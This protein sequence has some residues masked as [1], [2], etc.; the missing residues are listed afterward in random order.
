M[1]GRERMNAIMNKKPADKLAWTTIVDNATLNALPTE[2][3]GISGIDFYRYIGCDI[4][5]LNCW[6][7]NMDFSSPQLVWSEE[8]TTGYRHDEDKAIHELKSP[9]GTLTTIYRNGHPLKYPVTSLKEV[10]IYRQIWESA[11]FI[12]HDDIQV[13]DNVNAIIGED[14]I[15]TRFWGP[16]TIPRLLEYDMGVIN[17]YYQLKDYPQE[18]E[19]LINTIHERELKAFE[20]LAKGP[21]DVIILCENTSSFYISPE[22]YR[23]YNGPHVRDFVDIVHSEGKIAIIHMCGHVKN[24]LDKIKDTGL[25]GIHALTPS[26]TGDTAFE[27]ALDV[28]G[29]DIIIIGVLDPTIF[30]LNPIE[31]IPYALDE[32]YTSRL[33]HANFVLC[34]GADGITVPLERFQAVADWMNRNQ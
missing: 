11:Q 31:Q 19:A 9:E 7:V 13:Y 34:L 15:V 3:K 18:M 12:P 24:L 23:K 6:G 1:T 10:N 5:L 27:L 2:M 4:F 22:V 8:I 30:I 16:S 32:L 29:E 26:P 21:C 20:I 17:F 14:G 25:D 33:R 28:L